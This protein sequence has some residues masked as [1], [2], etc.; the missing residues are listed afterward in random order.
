MF[1]FHFANH[2][3]DTLTCGG[4]LSRTSHNMNIKRSGR[5][6]GARPFLQELMAALLHCKRRQHE[7]RQLDRARKKL[8]C[9]L[10]RRALG[11][12]AGQQRH[13][14]PRSCLGFRHPLGGLAGVARHV[15]SGTI[16][17]GK[18]CSFST[19]NSRTRTQTLNKQRALKGAHSHAL[20]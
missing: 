7:P 5:H 11:S 14:K 13:N 17:V 9:L 16:Y 1:E 4:Q 18:C 12:A 3:E 20:Q 19:T 2:R 6:G 8:W 15:C 10:Q